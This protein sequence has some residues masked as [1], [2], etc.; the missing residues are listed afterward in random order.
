MAYSGG[1]NFEPGVGIFVKVGDDLAI[2]IITDAE[3]NLLYDAE[4]DD[5]EE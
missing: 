5:G 3:G 1:I 4:G 2:M